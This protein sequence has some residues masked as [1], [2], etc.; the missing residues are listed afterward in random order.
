[1]RFYKE[2]G[3]IIWEFNSIGEFL[4]MLFWRVVGSIVGIVLILGTLYLIG[5]CSH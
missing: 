1:M 2:W 3:G 4:D 5:R